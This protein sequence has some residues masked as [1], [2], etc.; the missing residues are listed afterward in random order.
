MADVIIVILGMLVALAS[1][2]ICDKLRAQKKI[3][4]E[5]ARKIPHI[6][7]GCVVAYWP[8]FLSWKT[9][10]ILAFLYLLAAFL[11]KQV[12]LFRQVRFV[13]RITWGEYFYPVGVFVIALMQP[14]NA[15]FAVA[16]L[17]FAIADA[18]AAI[19]GKGYSTKK[20]QYKILGQTK[21]VLGSSIFWV[22]SFGLVAAVVLNNPMYESTQLVLILV[23]PTIAT[24][25]ENIGIY[26]SDN[27]LVPVAV[28]VMLQMAQTI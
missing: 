5:V 11:S 3:S 22:I 23:V 14:T 26:G 19:V 8:W 10:G 16:M 18:L 20:G 24:V 7:S 25:L 28:T 9:I 2:L 12:G 13:T 15:V 4:A 27:F 17:H 6:I 21:S 1:L